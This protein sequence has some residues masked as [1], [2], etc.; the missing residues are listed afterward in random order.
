MKFAMNS[1][2]DSRFSEGFSRSEF[3]TFLRS[4]TQIQYLMK[5]NR[6]LISSVKILKCFE[7]MTNFLKNSKFASVNEVD[8]WGFARSNNFY[9]MNIQEHFQTCDLEI[10]KN[11]IFNTWPHVLQHVLWILIVLRAEIQILDQFSIRITQV[12]ATRQEI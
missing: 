5:N 11:E 7:K 9:L 6:K 4:E 10:K 3:H 12:L 1:Q 8:Q 2:V